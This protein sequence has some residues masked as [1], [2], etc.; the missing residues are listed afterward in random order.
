MRFLKGDISSQP[1]ALLRIRTFVH[2]RSGDER[3]LGELA[4]GEELGREIGDE[5]VRAID[6]RNEQEW[7]REG[8]SNLF[9]RSEERRSIDALH[10]CEGVACCSVCARR[11]LGDK[12]VP[13]HVTTRRVE[14]GKRSSRP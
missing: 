1:P 6:H 13:D 3:D 9:P 4:R 5:A 7:F 14:E 12:G 11:D 10:A 2:V 8:R